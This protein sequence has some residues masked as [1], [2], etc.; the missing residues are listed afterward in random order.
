V[1]KSRDYDAEIAGALG[2]GSGE[3]FCQLRHAS[4][5]HTEAREQNAH[6]KEK[7]RNALSLGLPAEQFDNPWCQTG[8]Q[9]QY[10]DPPVAR[11]THVIFESEK[12]PSVNAKAGAPMHSAIKTRYLS[13]M[14]LALRYAAGIIKQYSALYFA[15]HRGR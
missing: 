11:L 14:D 6:H 8:N 12:P 4:S 1:G 15:F 7:P 9:W 13:S 2:T 5:L 3:V 10:R